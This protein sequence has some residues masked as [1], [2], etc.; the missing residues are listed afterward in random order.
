MNNRKLAVFSAIMSKLTTGDFVKLIESGK[1][2]A[3]K[4]F[5]ES[6]VCLEF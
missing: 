3:F 4:S 1:C 2:Q 6:L 5:V